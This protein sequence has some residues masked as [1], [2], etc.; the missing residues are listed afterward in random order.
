[1][2]FKKAGLLGPQLLVQIDHDDF[3]GKN[4]E[5]NQNLHQSES[6]NDLK[7]NKA[8]T[9]TI[10]TMNI[11]EKMFLVGDIFMRKYYT[12]FDRD[13]NRVGIAKSKGYTETPV[14]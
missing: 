10:V 11:K 9:S 7:K 13:Q 1:M 2:L 12:I 4:Q 5:I 6:V 8:C 14:E 3:N